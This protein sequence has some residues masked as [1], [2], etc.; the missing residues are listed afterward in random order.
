MAVTRQHIL[1]EIR[2]TAIE[3][4]GA[5]LGW[6]RFAK[7]TGIVRTDWLLIWARWGDAVREAGFAPNTLRGPLSESSI[8]EQYIGFTRELGRFPVISELRMRRRSQPDFPS[9]NV[10]AKRYGN[11]AGL[12]TRVLKYTQERAGFEDIVALCEAELPDSKRSVLPAVRPDAA[13]WGDVYLIRSGRYHKIGR[14]NA[15]GRRQYE[16]GIQLPEPSSMVH[17]IKTDD[18]AGIEAYW[19]HRFKHK[20]K[21]GEWF[22]LSGEDVAAFKR[23][24]FM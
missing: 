20:R 24:R 7:E 15:A 17:V 14:S 11:R 22:D 16:L 13:E 8:L 12:L 18:P 23:R 2:R 10:Y 5:A 9:D 3:N 1:A 21:R 6:R 4:G 19:H